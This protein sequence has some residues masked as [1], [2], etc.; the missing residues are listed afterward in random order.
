MP[1]GKTEELVKW[2]LRLNGYF[3]IPNF[4][5]HPLMSGGS[6]RTEIDLIG[7]RFPYQSEIVCNSEGDR[8]LME[9][10]KNLVTD[11][12]IDCLIVSVKGVQS[13]A[14]V[15]KSIKKF[16][17]LMDIIK[18]F[19]FVESEEKIAEVAKELLKEKR[20]LKDQFQIRFLAIAGKPNRYSESK[21]LIFHDIVD[22]ILKRFQ[23][24]C[25]YKVDTE[26]WE[27]VG[28]Q[29][30]SNCHRSCQDILEMIFNAG[31]AP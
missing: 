26:Q 21:Q 4:I 8:I 28:K 18:R 3:V 6:Q 24:Y 27:G 9:N 2:Y 10:D 17:N 25:Y 22:F 30:L 19:G 23:A 31:Q 11:R 29:I 16:E 5:L 7:T 13:Q 20:A 15:N 12:R 1:R 14:E